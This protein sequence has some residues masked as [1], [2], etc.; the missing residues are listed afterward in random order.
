MPHADF[1]HLRVHSAYSLSEG[2]I[3]IDELAAL[4]R[5]HEMPAVAVTD[6]GNLFGALE[7]SLACADAG[8]QPIIGCQLAIRGVSEEVAEDGH[9]AEATADAARGP[10]DQIV[11]L[12]QNEVGYRN[13][14]KLVS[15]SFL[16]TE[17][18]EAP[19]VT[20]ADLAE[21]GAGLIALTGGPAGP[22][23]RPL[24][25][26]GL[27]GAEAALMQLADLFPGRLYVEV[28]RHGTAVEARIEE[29][30]I[31]LA[32]KHHLP[33]VATNEAFFAEAQMYEAHDALLCIAGGTYVAEAERRRVTPHH[34][35]KSAAEMRALFADLPEAVDNTLAVAR[36]CAY[37]PR[38]RESM[39]PAF[40]TTG[41][42]SEADELRR[43]ASDG[44]EAHLARH[45]F[46]DTMDA[47]ARELAARPYRERLDFELG[48]ITDMGFAGYF[49]IVAD[50]IQWA[51]N[52]GI[53][54]GPGRGS[55]AGSV[56]AW[57]L[58]ITDL[59]PLRFGL[60][61]ERFL[62][63]E[64]VSMP[65]FD[66]DFCQDRRDEVIAYVQEKYGRDRVAQIITFGTLQARAAL[67][68]VGRVLQMPY[69]QVDRICK[70]VPN[71]PANPVPLGRAVEGEA[72][73]QRMRDE[74]PTV[75]RLIDIALKL[76]GL[77]RH[78]STHAAGV[79]IGD[80]PLD[81][82]VPL[83]R[84][85][86]SEM[87]VTQFSMKW[88]EKAG[89][90]KFD[91]L[92]L[93]TLTVLAR[94]EALLTARGIEVDLSN[95]PLDDGPTYEMMGR[96]EVT[97]VF[98]LE[99]S[100]MRDVLRR[101]RPDRFEDII[102]LV[103]LYRPGPMDN[104]PRFIACRHGEEEPDYLHESLEETLKETAGVMIYQEQ[105]M[106][107]AQVLSGYTLGGADL[108]RRAMGKKIK[109]EMEAQ[110]KAFIDGAVARGVD[111]G[112]ASLIF[113]QV[114][115]F[116]GY[117]FNKSHAA[118]YAMVAYQT[119]YL[120]ANHP[121]EFL[122]AS[123]T[124]DMGN[125]DKLSV[126]RQELDRLGIPLRP[127]DINH[128]GAD[129][130]VERDGEEAGPA[131]GAPSGAIRYALAA[132]KNV[133][134]AAMDA[135]V[136]ERAAQ[137]P[138]RD[139]FEVARRLDSRVVNKRQLESL[140]CAGAFDTLSPNRAQTFAAVETMV[141]YA[142]LASS[143]R[144][145]RQQ[146]LFG[147]DDPGSAPA[148]ALP[149]VSDWP[150]ADRLGHEFAAVGFYLSAH[151]L[152]AY[153][154]TLARLDVVSSADLPGKLNGGALRVKLAGTVIGKQERTSAR[155]N[156]FAFVQLSDASGIFEVVMFSETLAAARELLEPGTALLI[157]AEAR[158]EDDA[159]R[160]TAQQVQAL[161]AAAA[162]ADTSLK[163][164]VDAVAPIASL[165]GIMERERRGR[166]HIV[167]IVP[168]AE[169]REAE[170]TLPGRF[171]ITP[172]TRAAI[173]AI[174]GIVDVRES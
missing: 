86:R 138:F 43:Q 155:G 154:K 163:V 103:A 160:I 37:M 90:V 60:L 129:F 83:Y 111:K 19:H 106:Q 164:Y 58:T 22:V 32:Y 114:N 169:G 40:P 131:G 123:M 34:R 117:G 92:G 9:P 35:F 153:G 100:G 75:A 71:N 11:L 157:V 98:Q 120:K 8:I 107:I 171:A 18:A 15:R 39:L 105:V 53:P 121:V 41:G 124:L 110:R 165:R 30:L 173:K 170:V 62:N 168:L 152:D 70:M 51:R 87:A 54:V 136:A 127:P 63:P 85:P 79:V 28:T 38:P 141:R 25:E 104:I 88:A 151:P 24:G 10:M 146:S 48:T 109:S 150:V 1:V 52:A 45:V 132:V 12:A 69:G 172:P 158:L 33:L 101:L 50:F 74:D 49:L 122:A 161:D 6:T 99:S 42:V 174:P 14:L 143:E 94:A 139:L 149:D 115:K 66:I 159:P 27:L 96:A 72:A 102:A 78:A 47:G 67:R 89:L 23:G 2:A 97:G 137:G 116:A 95:L 13:L 128:S 17:G 80:Q 145:S 16:E 56:V 135:L 156:R 36:R 140:V 147:G 46:G 91:F 144:E 112:K 7:F 44:L 113:E 21:H 26:G 133:G 29:P 108:L 73:L 93:K 125:T 3:K 134:R 142:H 61:F 166:G 57:S 4:C 64:R 126:F 59:D 55:G 148:F 84:D 68:D 5:R 31:E 162:G 119:A 130:S 81:E 76:E 167:L 82:I 77:Y 118:A 20:V 65:D